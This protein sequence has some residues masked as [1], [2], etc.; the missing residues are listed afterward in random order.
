MLK[1]LFN[2]AHQG[3][4]FRLLR[5]SLR[6]QVPFEGSDTRRIRY[7]DKSRC[8]LLVRSVCLIISHIAVRFGRGASSVRTRSGAVWACS[9]W[10]A[11]VSAILWTLIR[12]IRGDMRWCP[13]GLHEHLR[14]RDR[15]SRCSYGWL[16]CAT[17]PV[18]SAKSLCSGD[19][20]TH[21]L[22]ACPVRATDVRAGSLCAADD[23]KMQ[24]RI[25]MFNVTAETVN[26]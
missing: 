10:T 23:N 14:I 3:A 13:W 11:S 2:E 19:G 5:L 12:G 15:H 24:T 7:G 9:L 26:S 20:W 17:C 16:S 4:K 18:L 25:G 6:P 8:N 21:A 22:C 1:P